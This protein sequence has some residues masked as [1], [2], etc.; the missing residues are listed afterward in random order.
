MNQLE[1]RRMIL[2]A[3]VLSV[4]PFRTACLSPLLVELTWNLRPHEVS[5]K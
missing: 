5:S 3:L 1:E 4:V 2:S